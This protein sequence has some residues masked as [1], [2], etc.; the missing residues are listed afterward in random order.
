MFH[1]N[2]ETVLQKDNITNKALSLQETLEAL[3]KDP[4]IADD[5]KLNLI[6]HLT[7]LTCALVAIQPIPFAD[8][9]ILSPIQVVMVMSMSRVLGNP[10]GKHGAGELV[11]SITGVVGWGVLAQQVVLGLYKTVIPFLG[12]VTT[13][14][15]VYAS[16]ISLGYA[17]KAIIEARHTDQ[18]ISQ[19]EL[20]RIQK[21]AKEQAATEK[22]NYQNVLQQLT[23]WQEKAKQYQLYEQQL[24]EQQ[25]N[26]D[27]LEKD[28][29]NLAGVV[30]RL[31]KQLSELQVVKNKLDKT[32]YL[33]HN[34][35]QQLQLFEAQLA[36]LNNNQISL[37]TEQEEKQ[38][39]VNQLQKQ[40]E[41]LHQFIDDT[42][43][44][45]SQLEQK[46]LAEKSIKDQLSQKAQEASLVEE[47]LE[48]LTDDRV[49]NLKS[50]IKT[51]YPGLKISDKVLK[52]IAKLSPD[53]LNGL[54]KQ[55]ALLCYA[56]DK[57]N[58]KRSVQGIKQTIQEIEFRHDG[59]L[60]VLIEGNMINVVRVGDKD[61]QPKDIEW[62]KK[63]DG[64]H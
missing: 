61:T 31:Q 40:I 24:A 11:A 30:E 64:Y 36:Q 54:E 18:Q 55:F 35:N 42:I 1:S 22:L 47:R 44:E 53:R 43:A 17:A 57:V 50:R 34:K 12:A 29:Q 62:I 60:Y 4:S 7:G 5:D 52:E 48:Q 16:T 33:L 59:R 8:L 51:C 21:L 32:T 26:L 58:F 37:I 23:Q 38:T 27:K 45:N 28:K 20:K 15:L 41:E 25:T 63:N 6:I 46:L 9:F 19:Q 56:I 10:V 49:A 39:R 14:P 13:V 2:Q 3:L